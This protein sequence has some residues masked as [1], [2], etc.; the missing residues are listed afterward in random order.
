[1]LFQIAITVLAAVPLAQRID[2]RVREYFDAGLFNGVVLVARGNQIVYQ[3]AFGLADRTFNI[4]NTLDTKFHIASLSKPIT[5]AAVL[6]LADR[7]KLRLEDP[8][9]KFVPDFP[10]GDRITIENLLTHTSGIGEPSDADYDRWSRFPQTPASLLESVKKDPP[11]GQPKGEYFY[12]ASN[13][14]LLAFIIE[15]VSGRNYGDFL[16]ENIFRPAGMSDTAHR[17][18]DTAI[19]PRLAPGY[20]P[21]GTAGFA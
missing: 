15:K 1:M 19:V 20:M 4:P 5:A 11:H 8:V 17:G 2:H 12:T 9:S 6:L 18:D 21:V 16:E 7:G 3:K 14:N 13:Y 10:N